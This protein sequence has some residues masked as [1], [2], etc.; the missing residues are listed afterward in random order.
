MI[1]VEK[2]RRILGPALSQLSDE[3]VEV[4]R[5]QLYALADVALSILFTRFYLLL[6]SPKETVNIAENVCVEMVAA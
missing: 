5:D 6:F 3:E 1:S 4:K 2:C